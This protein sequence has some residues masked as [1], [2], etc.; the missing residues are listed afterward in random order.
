MKIYPA[1][2]QLG[3]SY[4]PYGKLAGMAWLGERYYFFVNSNSVA[5][6]P[7]SLFHHEETKAQE[8]ETGP[9]PLP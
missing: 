9:V 6:M 7:A 3:Q 4:P 8:R 1:P 5:M 2:L